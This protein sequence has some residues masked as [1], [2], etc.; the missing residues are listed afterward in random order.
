MRSNINRSFVRSP[1]N[2]ISASKDESDVFDSLSQLGA[3]QLKV[4][5]V[6]QRESAQYVLNFGYTVDLYIR[7]I[8][9]AKVRRS[10]MCLGGKLGDLSFSIFS[11]RDE[12]QG[13]M[14][15]FGAD[16]RRKPEEEKGK[17]GQDYGPI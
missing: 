7:M 15:S 1:Q 3:I 5:E 17:A 6:H 12:R 11:G 10:R 13:N 16:L 14:L 9:S 8:D 4:E 2:D